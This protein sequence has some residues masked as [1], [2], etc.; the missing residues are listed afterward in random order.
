[1]IVVSVYIYA[2]VKMRRKPSTDTSTGCVGTNIGADIGTEEH[3]YDEP[4]LLLPHT[5]S[6]HAS[7]FNISSI[8]NHHQYHH[9]YPG[10]HEA[11]HR[12]EPPQYPPSPV[13]SISV[14][15]SENSFYMGT[16]D[17]QNCVQQDVHTHIPNPADNVSEISINGA[18]AS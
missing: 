8:P 11:Y 18:V 4:H 1:L 16:E 7:P 14:H 5:S 2:S 3:I 9:D 6:L 15:N 10:L 12:P 17:I 13:R